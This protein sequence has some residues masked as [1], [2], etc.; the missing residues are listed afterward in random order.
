MINNKKNFTAYKKKP[1]RIFESNEN[2]VI[3]N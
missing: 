3:Y 1:K 2:E